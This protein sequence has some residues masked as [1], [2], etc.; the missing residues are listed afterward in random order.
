MK[1]LTFLL[2]A[3]VPPLLLSQAN[4][5]LA[6][7]LCGAREVQL[8]NNYIQIEPNG[9]DDTANIQCALDLAV[10]RNIPEI[11]LARGDFYISALAVQKFR[12]TLQGGGKDYTRIRLLEGSIDC[13]F[14]TAAIT[15]AGGEPRIR[16]LSLIW[17]RGLWPCTPGSGA[18]RA[19][20]HFTGVHDDP[21]S[22]SSDV[23]AATVDRADLEGPGV[24]GEFMYGT[25][26]RVEPNDSP[27]KCRNVLLGSFQLNRSTVSHFPAGVEFQMRGGATMSVHMNTFLYNGRGLSIRDSGATVSVARNYFSNTH[28]ASTSAC[29]LAGIGI[30]V[31][32]AEAYREVTR[33]DVH[34]NTFEISDSDNCAGIA[35]VITQEPAAAK[36]SIAISN[37]DFVLLGMGTW[38]GGGGSAIFSQGAS[39]AVVKNNRFS[40]TVPTRYQSR[41]RVEAGN[42]EAVAGW[43]IDSNWGFAQQEDWADIFLGEKVKHTLI[44]PGQGAVVVDYGYEN[45][46]L[47]Q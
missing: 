32:N 42:M 13:G 22:C 23:I 17:G 28:I 10:D 11:R 19:L 27:S 34:A 7:S 16:W 2:W 3:L 1:T 44:G 26:L 33:L 46:V 35:L 25:A 39:S 37:N 29:H 20:I 24:Y 38:Y 12:G 43:T 8:K 47:P 45:T 5:T 4:S 9:L 30:A 15:F 14:R 21:S 6:E 41:I 40:E 36:V 18:L 31:I